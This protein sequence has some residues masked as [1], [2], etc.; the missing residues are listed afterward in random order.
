MLDIPH[1]ENHHQVSC[2]KRKKYFKKI[3]L[4]CIFQQEYWKE[5]RQ[6]IKSITADVRYAH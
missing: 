3:T 6:K 2:G 1:C 5:T 4:G